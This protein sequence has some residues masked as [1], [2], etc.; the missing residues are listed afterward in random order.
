M[1]FNLIQVELT[2]YCNL[3]CSFCYRKYM[4]RPQGF[5]TKRTFKK[6]LLLG[7]KL[8]VKEVW[9]H[10]FGESMLHPNLVKFIRSGAKYFKVGF[11]TNGSLLT[12]E[13]LRELKKN[14]LSYLDISLNMETF[15]TYLVHLVSMYQLANEIGLDCRFRSVINSLEEYKYLLSLF[16]E[17]KI[18]WQRAM[19]RNT[20]KVRTQRCLAKDKVC[21]ILWTGKVSA[22]CGDFNGEIIYGNIGDRNIVEKIYTG[23]KNID[24]E[25]PEFCRHCFEIKD[26]LPIRYK[27]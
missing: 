7:K 17:F 2:N 18:R 5:I 26:D 15:K 24:K 10:N 12:F 9:L 13:K 8:K 21:V 14:N 22:C 4:V 11:A 19:I 1:A 27:L 23:Q 25:L 3:H 20:K 16:K 6:A